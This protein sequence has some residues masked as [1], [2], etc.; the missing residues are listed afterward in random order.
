MVAIAEVQIRGIEDYREVLI[1]PVCHIRF[2]F[3]ETIA[4]KNSCP[5]DEE[6]HVSIR[7][8]NVNIGED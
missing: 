5:Y 3:G 4:S 6:R 7:F 2:Q 8:D 1:S